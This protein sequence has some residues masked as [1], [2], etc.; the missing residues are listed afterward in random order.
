MLKK[1]TEEEPIKIPQ[2]YSKDLED[3]IKKMLTKDSDLRP[4]LK[5]ILKLEFLQKTVIIKKIYYLIKYKRS[6]K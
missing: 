6:M 3:L 4:N 2:N 1:I 5:K